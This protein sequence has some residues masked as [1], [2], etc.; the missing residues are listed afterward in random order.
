MM[1][2][3]IYLNKTKE[4]NNLRITKKKIKMMRKKV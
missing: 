4:V 3:K 1:M 2:K